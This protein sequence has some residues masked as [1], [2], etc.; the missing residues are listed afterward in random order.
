MVTQ[1]NSPIAIVKKLNRNTS[2]S[3]KPFIIDISTETIK[4]LKST[5]NNDA[6]TIFL[7]LEIH[8]NEITVANVPN[9]TSYSPNGLIIFVIKHAIVNGVKYLLSKKHNKTNASAI[10]NWIG[11]KEKTPSSSDK[12]T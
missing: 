10:L 7:H 4:P 6:T 5:G 2:N 9:I 8:S 3:N 11:P 12:T 1:T